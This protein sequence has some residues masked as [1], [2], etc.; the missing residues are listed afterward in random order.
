M[1]LQAPGNVTAKARSPSRI[2]LQWANLDAYDYIEIWENKAGAGY[3]DTAKLTIGGEHEGYTLTG[4]DA[5]TEYCYKLVGGTYDPEEESAFSNEDCATTY[6][7]LGIPSELAVT[8][9]SDCI[10]LTFKDNSSSEDV[11][12]IWRRDGG[13]YAKIAD[14]LDK[15]IEFYRDTTV[16]AG[17]LYY[18]KVRARQNPS[19]YSDYT[20]EKSGTANNV[21]NAPTGPTLSGITDEEMRFSWTAPAAGF[22]VTGYRIEKSDTDTFAEDE[23]D[24]IAIVD[25]DVFE[26][27]AKG[28]SASTPYWFRVRAYNGK[29]NGSYTSAA[30]DTT[31][32]Q[33]VKT[34]FEVFV[35]DPNIK[36]VYIAE[37]ELKMNLSGFT[38]T[39][40]QTKTFEVEID[41][42]GLEIDGVWEDGT[43]LTEKAS[44]AQVEATASTWWWDTSVRKLYVH[45]S[46]DADPDDFF[47]EGGFTHLIPN[48]K[49][50]YAD[51]LCTLPP[52][53]SAESIPSVTQEMKPYYEGSFRLSTGSI[54]F[55]NALSDGEH[56]FDKRFEK[57][58]WIGAKLTIY[59]GKETF[60]TLAKF[61]KIFTAYIS[62][63]SCSERTITLSLAGIMKELERAFVLNKFWLSD[64]PE[65][66]EEGEE[67]DFDGREIPKGFGFISEIA[68]VAIEKYDSTENTSAK[69]KF[70]DGRIKDVYKVTVNDVEKTKDT[71]YYVDYQRGIVIFNSSV[72]I[73]EDDI[74]LVD[75]NGMVNS[76]DEVINNGAEIFKYLMNNE[77]SVPTTKLNADW[78]YETKYADTKT[79]SPYFYK[80]TP[81]DEVIKNLEH[82]TEAY[83]LQDGEGRVGLRPLQTTASSKVKYIGNFQ[84]KGH[85]HNKG[86][87]SLY[88]KVEVYYN[89]NPQTQEWDVK[90]AKNDEIKWQYGVERI[91]P[92]VHTYIGNTP[93]QAQSLATSIL[94]L[95]NK[96]YIEDE[97]P[98]ILFDVFPGD[99]IKFSRTRFFDTTGTASEV[100]MRL[101]RVEKN[102]QTGKTSVKIEKV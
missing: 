41:E 65:A 51:D 101:L 4:L 86:K 74:V 38:L 96:T 82:T 40:E 77:F 72:A 1:A 15:N 62:G 68:P 56:Y 11:F 71:H 66:V 83:V 53:L 47:M 42:R 69:F 61:G 13:E 23:G 92:P 73:E 7:A 67:W 58:T 24:L 95:L 48:R 60:S 64:Y 22:E 28:L 17:T 76:A 12:E 31:L 10:E 91:L 90:D 44:I 19:D 52:W 59:C 25:S 14:T 97:L 32:D 79:I 89:E 33:Y 50:D 63:K 29:G 34:D 81:I 55:I 5:N 80:D 6:V 35:R 49:F 45:S 21:P 93:S 70:Q 43:A 87:D 100:T 46:T 37:I 9:F 85:R 30:T 26:Y 75:F 2:A 3:G 18:Y 20:S 78:I 8:V 27:L 54:S 84:S 39:A 98:A 88:W 16:V 36:P 102:P 99:L 57:F 94:S